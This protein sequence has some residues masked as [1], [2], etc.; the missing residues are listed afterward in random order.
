[1]NRVLR[2]EAAI[3]QTKLISHKAVPGNEMMEFRGPTC[4]NLKFYLLLSVRVKLRFQFAVTLSGPDLNSN[5]SAIGVCTWCIG[6]CG[7]HWAT[8][9][10]LW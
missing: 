1:M 5:I 9:H 6:N 4:M 10:Q 2:W 8:G 7:Q 3:Q